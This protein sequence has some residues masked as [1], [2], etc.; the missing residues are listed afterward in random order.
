M[1]GKVWQMKIGILALQGDIQEHKTILKKLK[2]DVV[3]VRKKEDLKGVDGLIIPGGE[4]TTIGKLMVDYGLDKEIIEKA[5]SGMG[6]YG[7]CA[8]AILL[9]KNI[10]HSTQPRLGLMDIVI[11]RNAYGRQL[12]S[13]EAVLDIKKI[14]KF[15]GVFIRAPIIESCKDA[16]VLASYNNH[17]V[18]LVHQ[19]IMITTFH[20]ELTDDARIHKFFIELLKKQ[21][22]EKD[23]VGKAGLR[24][25]Y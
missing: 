20:P 15:H 8:G 11:E 24:H 25:Y 13:F 7:T 16:E 1:D 6:I 5:K 2:V 18:F 23:H 3:E 17:P 22:K 9:S 14:G 10:K 19:H 21:N 12:E 4:S